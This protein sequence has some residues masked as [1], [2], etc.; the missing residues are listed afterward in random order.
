MH[1]QGVV[2]E[3]IF[4]EASTDVL[5]RRYEETRRAHP[6]IGEGSLL[7]G[8]VREETQLTVLRQSAHHIINTSFL[9]VHQLRRHLY[10]LFG[11]VEKKGRSLQIELISFSY[12]RGLPHYADFIMD[13][14]FLPN[15]HYEL[16][17]REMDGRKEE[18]QQYISRDTGANKI[19]D[20]F[21]ALAQAMI[22]YYEKDD[23]TYFV[24]AV[25]CT[26]GKH[27]SVAVVCNLAARLEAL[28]YSPQVLHRDIDVK[29]RL[30]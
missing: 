11:T 13:V 26:G 20:A 25:G 7:E 16:E 18:I 22:A 19:L 28:G 17:L 1:S 10:N 6:L 14:R 3:V 8:I 15:P 30:Q 24:F 2:P 9:N 12:A 27:R 21:Y 5:L 4:L 23:R 29:K